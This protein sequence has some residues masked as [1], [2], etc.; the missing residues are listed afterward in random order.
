MYLLSDFGKSSIIRKDADNIAKC[1]LTAVSNYINNLRQDGFGIYSEDYN[2]D[3]FDVILTKEGEVYRFCYT[4]DRMLTMIS[5]P[6]KNSEFDETYI[7]GKRKEVD[8]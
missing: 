3:R 7:S 6:Y 8:N 5:K 1:D 4:N 2:K